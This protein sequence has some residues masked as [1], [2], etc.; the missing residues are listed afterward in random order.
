VSNDNRSLP[1]I[2]WY[3]AMTESAKKDQFVSLDLSN[4]HK[5]TFLLGVMALYGLG[6]VEKDPLTA[7][8]Y[9]GSSLKSDYEPALIG[10][11]HALIQQGN[12]KANSRNHSEDYG[13]AIKLIKK[14]AKKGSE[15]ALHYKARLLKTGF[16]NMPRDP[17]KATKILKKLVKNG[18]KPASKDLEPVQT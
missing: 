6:D 3:K 4:H 5:A 17:N 9:F 15:A 2:D 14:A 12:Q 10:Y 16:C 7:A 11:C 18:Y 1:I 13:R 8:F